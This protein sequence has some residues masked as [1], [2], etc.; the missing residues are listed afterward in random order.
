MEN[1]TEF[2]EFT[3]TDDKKNDLKKTLSENIYQYS[4]FYPIYNCK[5]R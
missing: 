5:T 1:F 4:F 3:R 2:A